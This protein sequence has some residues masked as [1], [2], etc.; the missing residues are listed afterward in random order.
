MYSPIVVLHFLNSRFLQEFFISQAAELLRHPHLQPYVLQVNLKSSPTYNSLPV[1]HP[2]SSHIKKIRFPDDEDDSVCKGK[3]KRHSLGN[4]RIL[5]QDRPTTK[6]HSISSTRSI[7]YYSDTLNQGMKDLSI[8]SSQF[9][10]SG[11]TRVANAKLTVTKTPRYTPS[12]NFATPRKQVEPV[13]A[14]Q[15]GTT[16]KLVCSL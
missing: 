2:V 9:G 13:K 1:P 14:M 11:V 4:E 16:H 7:K 8:G 10:E 6:R 12:K 5:R 15:S 3:E